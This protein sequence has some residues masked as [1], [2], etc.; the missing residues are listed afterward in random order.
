[1]IY[2]RTK[3]PDLLWLLLFGV[4]IGPVF[5]IIPTEFFRDISPIIGT[6]SI[7][8]I[9]FDAGIDTTITKFREIIK[10]TSGLTYLT[11]IFITL[12]TG[13]VSPWIIPEFTFIKGLIL[14][15]MLG[16][17]STVAVYGLLEQISKILPDLREVHSMLVLEST[18]VDPIRIMVAVSLI[19]VLVE[20]DIHYS[21]TLL[22]IFSVFLLGSLFG[23]AA[24]FLWIFILHRFEGR[25]YNYM[26]TVSILFIV[27]YLAEITFGEG[28]G[29]MASFIFGV[30]LSN[31][32]RITKEFGFSPRI[33]IEEIV[34]FNKEIAFVLKAYFFV[35]TGLIVKLNFNLLYTGITLTG[36]LIIV[37]FLVSSGVSNILDF[38]EVEKNVTRLCYPLGTSALVFAQ[39]PLIY[40]PNKIAIT[41]PQIYPNLVFY[42][43]LGSIMFYSLIAPII[44]KKILKDK[45]D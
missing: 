5:K 45:K 33:D 32:K 30:T 12:S 31:P 9:T 20:G 15:T 18:I 19:K 34:S 7:I 43:V 2:R 24:G 6:I 13:V 36:L 40:D 23:L 39:L 21:D 17:L 25:R 11:F 35:Y 37:R 22:S 1:M 38:T 28:A 42:V 8:L 3:I 27:Y 14:G 4:I 41:N 10:K 26:L 29:T 44:M 16:G